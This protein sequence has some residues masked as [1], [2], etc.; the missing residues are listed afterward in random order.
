MAK[1][2][3]RRI[4]TQDWYETDKNKNGWVSY[5]W[6][7]DDGEYMGTDWTIVRHIHIDKFGNPLRAVAEREVDV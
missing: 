6:F 2:I 7:F 3:E 5:G 1:V 4:V